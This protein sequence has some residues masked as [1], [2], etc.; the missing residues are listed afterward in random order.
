MLEKTGVPT[1]Q[2][3]AR[4][5]PPPERLAKGP[6]VVIECFQRIPCNPCYTACKQGAIQEFADLNDL[7]VI[8]YD[9]CNG[10]GLCISKCPG[11]A[12]F[13]VDLTYSPD[14]ALVKMPY[15]FLPVPEKGAQVDLLDRE[16][17]PVG[18]G[19][20]ERVQ[21]AAGMDRTLV[22]WVAVPRELSW[23]VRNIRVGGRR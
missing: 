18:R 7:P 16:G 6:V 23:Q 3:L 20:V 21:N 11:R 8:D 13:V 15:E 4:V 10:C 12:I 19:R 14:V 1:E 9:R 2:D 17:K 5:I 22:V